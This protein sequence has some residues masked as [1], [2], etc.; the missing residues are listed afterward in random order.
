M[1]P[2]STLTKLLTFSLFTASAGGTFAL[3]SAVP[4][5]AQLT[6]PNTPSS[7][8]FQS[9][10]F[11]PR[12]DVNTPIQPVRGVTTDRPAGEWLRQAR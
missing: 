2:K 9:R 10:A 5:I 3:F 8:S 6:E 7:H 4:L 11:H 12:R 1:S